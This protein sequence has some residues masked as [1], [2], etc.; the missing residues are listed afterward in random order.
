MLHGHE[1]PVEETPAKGPAGTFLLTEGGAARA[2]IVR[3]GP[4]FVCLSAYVTPI[5]KS[6]WIQDRQNLVSIYHDKIGLILGGGNTKLQPAWSNFT[7]GDVTLLSHRPG[8]AH[9]VDCPVGSFNVV[10]VGLAVAA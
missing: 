6:R 4:W 8:D 1:G 9:P 10:K 7:V 2:A 3:R 5:S